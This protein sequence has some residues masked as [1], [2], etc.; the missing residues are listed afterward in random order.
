MIFNRRKIRDAIRLKLL[1]VITRVHSFVLRAESKSI[2]IIYGLQTGY[3]VAS[4]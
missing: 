3:S 2:V 1:V 4:S